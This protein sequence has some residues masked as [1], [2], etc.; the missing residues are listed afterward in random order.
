MA[1]IAT[2]MNNGVTLPSLID[3]VSNQLLP[4]LSSHWSDTAVEHVHIH[5][6]KSSKER[7]SYSNFEKG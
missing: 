3:D 7:D 2:H 5:Q 6:A 1:N 4:K